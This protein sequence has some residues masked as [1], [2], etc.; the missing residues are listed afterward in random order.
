[1]KPK[2]ATLSTLPLL[3]AAGLLLVA[4][5]PLAAAARS[6]PI[7]PAPRGFTAHLTCD[8]G[9]CPE[10]TRGGSTRWVLADF[11]A[12]YEIVVGNPSDLWVEA[13][14]TVDGRNILDGYRASTRSRGYLVP[15]HD[16]ITIE[17]WRTSS[18]DVAA[19]RFTSRGDSYAGRVGDTRDLGVIKV[20][21]FPESAPRRQWIP[22]EPVP[23]DLESDGARHD[24]AGKSAG[25]AA[26]PRASADSRCASARC[27]G[28]DGGQNL[29]TQFGES[30]WSPV[31]ERDFTR[32][33]SRPAQVTTIRYD[34]RAGLA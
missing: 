33:S 20:E 32:A 8:G 25:E 12:R 27:L 23:W 3:A 24:H 18:Q 19:F 34:D 31:T 10:I 13:V 30:R 29:G 9:G 15:P 2:K 6:R 7:V 22:E 16:T 11:G 5:T 17:G 28:V 26:A 4:A 1:M 14:V 21:F